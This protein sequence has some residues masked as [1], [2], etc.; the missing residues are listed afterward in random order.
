MSQ[1]PTSP[2]PHGQTPTYLQT[3]ELEHLLRQT[4][5]P[6]ELLVED[7]SWQHAGHVGANE[8]GLGSHF[9]VKISSPALVGLGLVQQH[10]LI[11]QAL[12]PVMNRIHALRIAVV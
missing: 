8:Q 9:Y 10:R 7:E 1:H 11:Y 12:S 3:H 2:P 5:Q 4:L 6:N